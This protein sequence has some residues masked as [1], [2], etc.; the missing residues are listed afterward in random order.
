MLQIVLMPP[1]MV[2]RRTETQFV[3]S[4]KQATTFKMINTP[5]T[6]RIPISKWIQNQTISKHTTPDSPT[7]TTAKEK[8][9]FTFLTSK[10]EFAKGS[11]CKAPTTHLFLSGKSIPK[12][13]PKNECMFRNSQLK[14]DK[15]MTI[16]H[17]QFGPNL[18][19]SLCTRI[20]PRGRTPN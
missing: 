4:S 1:Q 12:H 13:Q 17:W 10:A 8:M 2:D 11:T 7:K 19:P 15:L 3:D 6:K 14:P 16:N 20:F 9:F 18:L 5:L